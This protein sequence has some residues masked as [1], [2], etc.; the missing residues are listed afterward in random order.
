MNSY[1]ENYKCNS[2]FSKEFKY[3]VS[4]VW[5]SGVF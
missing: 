1:H 4:N 5:D 3:N 2:E